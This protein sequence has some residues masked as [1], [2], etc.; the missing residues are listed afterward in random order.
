MQVGQELIDAVLTEVERGRLGR[1]LGTEGRGTHGDGKREVDQIETPFLQLVMTRI[2][3]HERTAGSSVLRK[4]TLEELGGGAEIVRA[5]L[6]DALADLEPDEAETAAAMFQYLVTPSGTKIAHTAT[7]LATMTER[8]EALVRKVLRKLDEERILRGV[9]PTPESRERRF[10]IFHDRLAGPILDWRHEE[11]ALRLEREK[12]DAERARR[13]AE[14]HAEV[15]EQQAARIR[16][17]AERSARV[18]GRRGWNNLSGTQG[19]DP[20][21]IYSPRSIDEVAEIVRAAEA[22]GST[23]KA[24]GSGLSWSDVA[25]TTGFLMKTDHLSLVPAPDPDFLRPEWQDRRLVRAGAGVRIRELNTY[26]ANRHLALGNVGGYDQ[27]TIA[28]AISTSTHGSGMSFG[29]LNDC[30]HSLDIVGAGG[31]VY[32]IERSDGP[33]DRAAFEN[34]FSDRR[35]LI[36][37]DAWFDAASVGMGCMGVICS[38]MLEVRPAY[39]LREVRRFT[40]WDKV[41]VDLVAGDV[42]RANRHYE[43]LL[44]PYS[45][46]GSRPCVVITRNYSAHRPVE[47]RT[48][49]GHA[50][51]TEWAARLPFRS[52]LLNRIVAARPSVSP[53]LLENA[54]RGLAR[55][56]Y[57]DVSY[58]VLG[59]NAA[60][61]IP[62]YSCEFAVPMDG[63]HIEAVEVL[64][65]VAAE[66]ARL[67]D[68]YQHA[69]ISLRFV[70]AS[71]AYMS[72]MNGTDTMMIEALQLTHVE[73]GYN[74]LAAYEE[75]LYRLGSRPHWGQLN[76]LTDGGF[77]SQMYPRFEEWLAVH[78]RLNASGVFDGPFSRRVGISRPQFGTWAA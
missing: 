54:L 55:G 13:E 73:G 8:P 16:W 74:L 63:R 43:L 25:L 76:Q 42:L 29:P 70:R 68:L 22:A 1:E 36:Q 21:R 33:T 52:T 37:D 7:D 15:A 49:H 6:R 60:A 45:R 19:M 40:T 78:R 51:L 2:W 27:A 34:H 50:R 30:V 67:G 3:A 56:E 59:V 4:A 39:Y 10:E 58:K 12:R 71:P 28:G 11:R 17:T 18:A 72:M 47:A 62:A 75:A 65:R 23:A 44:S 14:Q 53:S 38:V 57:I 5:H 41:K 32:R 77:L 48:M 61:M 66:Q 26:L 69:P 35:S 20:L 64:I 46:S 24:V 9:D 31:T